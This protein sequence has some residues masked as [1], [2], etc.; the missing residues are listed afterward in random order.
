MN[1][2]II[3]VIAS[4]IGSGLMAGITYAIA[5]ARAVEAK[6]KEPG[7]DAMLPAALWPFYLPAIAGVLLVERIRARHIPR[8]IVTKDPT[9]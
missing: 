9:P 4:I 7:V 2:I 8:A 1:A 6:S 3:I 5:Y